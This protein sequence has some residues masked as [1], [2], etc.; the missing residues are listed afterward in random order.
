MANHNLGIN[1]KKLEKMP[2]RRMALADPV[3][4]LGAPTQAK[5]GN[6][7]IDLDALGWSKICAYATG[8]PIE[9]LGRRAR[10]FPSGPVRILDKQHQS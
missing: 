8:I 6:T 4:L 2:N 3:V 1:I 9:F 7:L 10:K 5:S